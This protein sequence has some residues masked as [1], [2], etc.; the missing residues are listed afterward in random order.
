MGAG[1]GRVRL[2]HRCEPAPIMRSI[3]LPVRRARREAE[4]VRT[5]IFCLDR[6]RPTFCSLDEPERFSLIDRWSNRCAVQPVVS[7][8][9][10]RDRELVVVLPPVVRILDFNTRED[11]V[12]R[13]TKHTICGLLHHLN[14][15]GRPT[16][17]KWRSCAS[18]RSCRLPNEKIWFR[19]ARPEGRPA[20][21]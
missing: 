5:P 8:V 20:R 18:A 7:E 19:A 16:D 12:R 17:R 11:A 4:L 10:E 6:S 3:A 1:G 14:Q 9:V 2:F 15:T 21:S 13:E